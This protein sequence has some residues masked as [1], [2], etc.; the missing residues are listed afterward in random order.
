MRRRRVVLVACVVAALALVA[1]SWGKILAAVSGYPDLAGFTS[2]QFCSNALAD[3]GPGVEEI[4]DPLTEEEEGSLRQAL[5]AI[6][7]A[8]TRESATSLPAEEG[9]WEKMFALAMPDGRTLTIKTTSVHVVVLGLGAWK[10]D[11]LSL[12]ALND[13]YARLYEGRK[14]ALDLVR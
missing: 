2:A 7:L 1:L 8:G 13:C 14:D 6:S 10:A 5:S 9:G 12:A 3:G 4:A 11:P